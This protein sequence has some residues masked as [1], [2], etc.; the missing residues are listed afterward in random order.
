MAR[1]VSKRQI[2]TGKWLSLEG[3]SYVDHYGV[4]REWESASRVGG[5]GAVAVVA[6]MKPSGRLVLVRQ[7]RPPAAGHTV[8]FPAGLIDGK[9]KP[10]QTALRE[11]YEE[12]GY[13]GKVLEITRPLYSSPGMTG[14]T[15]HLVCIEIDEN[16]PENRNL[17]T[18]FDEGEHIETFLVP[19]DKILDFLEKACRKG[20]RLDAKVTSF[21]VGIASSGRPGVRR[22]K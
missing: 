3:I 1:I 13:S 19:M 9:E 18:T 22:R 21:A 4:A 16:L 14:E 5:G 15:V 7:F 11:L 8:E 10:G 20:D 17:K 12:T 6:T 2:A